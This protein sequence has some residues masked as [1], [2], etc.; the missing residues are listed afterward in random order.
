[1]TRRASVWVVSGSATR[2]IAVATDPAQMLDADDV[3]A[4]GFDVVVGD[5]REVDAFVRAASTV[6]AAGGWVSVDAG[7]QLKP[8]IE[9]SLSYADV[10]VMGRAA[11]TELTGTYDAP[12]A[13]QEL[14]DGRRLAV[15]TA[16]SDG[17]WAADTRSVWYQP[18]FE[19]SVVDSNGAGDSF[20][21][22]LVA[23][24][25]HGLSPRQAVRW[26]AATSALRVSSGSDAGL[27]SQTQVAEA[28][29]SLAVRQ[30]SS[31]SS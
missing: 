29:T 7:A 24:F 26:A 1:M 13:V 25:V 21:G 31:T 3:D 16:G 9:E 28:L 23:A 18:A 11:A 10:V 4:S 19:V 14:V 17:C 20:H 6:R 15:V 22:G 12:S 5:G 30:P 27:P 8:R 2:T